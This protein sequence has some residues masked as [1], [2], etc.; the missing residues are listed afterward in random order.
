MTQRNLSFHFFL[1]RKR[2]TTK[3]MEICGSEKNEVQAIANK[4]CL[5]PFAIRDLFNA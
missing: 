2:T 4:S 3:T 5:E 1:L